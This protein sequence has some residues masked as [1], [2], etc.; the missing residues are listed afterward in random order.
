MAEAIYTTSTFLHI[1][2][3]ET[4]NQAFT[5]STFLPRWFILFVLGLF[6]LGLPTPDG[7]FLANSWN[8]AWGRAWDT[9]PQSTF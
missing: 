8:D 4:V 5:I 6:V 9:M 7:K 3:K 2:E 1:R